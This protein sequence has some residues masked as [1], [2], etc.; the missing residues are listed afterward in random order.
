MR[1]KYPGMA[2]FTHIFDKK[3]PIPG[4]NFTQSSY[5]KLKICSNWTIV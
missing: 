1:K 5:A 4:H 2:H 3:S